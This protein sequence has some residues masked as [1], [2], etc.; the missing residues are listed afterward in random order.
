MDMKPTLTMS[1]KQML[2]M[3]PKLQQAIKILQMPRLE[4]SQYITQQLT[5]NPVLEE[6]EDIEEESEEETENSEE[7]I[8]DEIPELDVDLETGLPDADSTLESDLPEIDITNDDFGDID[9]KEYFE[10][11]DIENSEWEEP[12]EDDR[13]DNSPASEESLQDHLLWQLR[14][15]D[16]T[17]KEY[18]IGEAIIGEINDDG[19]LTEDVNELAKELG[20]EIVDVEKV[21]QIIQGFDPIGVG[22]RDLRECLLIQLK[23]L[24]LEGTIPYRIID[25]GYLRELE[26]NKYPQIAK[27]LGVSIDL[28]KD[29]VKIIS[30]LE[31]KPGRQYSPVKNEYII[32]DVI[33]EKVDGKYTVMMNDFGPRLTISPYYKNILTSGE[34]LQEDTKKYI[35]SQLESASWFLESLERRRKT[36]LK[37]T[38]AIFEV[39]KDFLEKGPKYLKPL[40]LRDVA[41]AVGVHEG[42][43]SRVVN[44]RYVQT[45]QG[46]FELKHFFSSGISTKDGQMT[47]STSVKEMIKSLIDSEDPKNPLSDNE[48]EIILKKKGLNIA[49]RTI[50]KYRKELKIP[51]SSKR[52]QW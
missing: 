26:A 10:D 17:E 6:I 12:I 23:Q 28:V 13:R 5:E 45:P 51:S 1:Q 30:S 25:E 47:S 21:L 37:V 44:N 29:A 43:V 16:I 52:K 46:I 32:P 7:E 22:A 8:I 20:Y 39:Q 40:V 42:T 2:V 4:L 38:E 24:N 14:M 11:R 9:W 19:Y 27:S 33:V 49:R 35:Q 50:A 41:D 31:P 3:T 36:I 15:S 48:I 18:E 34:P